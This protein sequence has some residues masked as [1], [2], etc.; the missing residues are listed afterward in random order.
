MV[1]EQ[2]RDGQDVDHSTLPPSLSAWLGHRREVHDTITPRT[3]AAFGAML[4]GLLGPGTVPPGLHWCLAPDIAPSD[5]L[6]RDGHPRPGM[7]QPAIPLP[8]R[9][10]AGGELAIDGELIPNDSVT[11]ISTVEAITPRSGRSGPL[12]FLTM[13]HHWQVKG[14]TRMDERQ[15]LVFRADPAS[16]APTPAP[17]RAEPWPTAQRWPLTPDSTLL[18]RYSA[19]SFNGHRIHYDHPYATEVE[20]Y[21]GLLTH[22]PLQ[23]TLMLNLAT[24]VVGHLPTRF[25]YRALTP[26]LVGEKISVEARRS[27][28]GLDLRIRRE[29][30]GALTMAAHSS[31]A[32]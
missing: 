18:F 8:R 1:M 22:G 20:G 25:S 15:D 17:P 4:P 10:W 28:E 11:R 9:M 14:R 21:A 6:G 12:W 16:G 2:P 24:E 7:F 26:L 23:A 29:R 27:D 19:L 31:P 32:G 5:E 30:D 13:R 3:I